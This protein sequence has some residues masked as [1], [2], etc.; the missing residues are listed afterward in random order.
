MLSND[1]IGSQKTFM[2]V[3]RTKKFIVRQTEKRLIRQLLQDQ[4]DLGLLCLQKR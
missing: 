3:H 2:L 4:P 1:L